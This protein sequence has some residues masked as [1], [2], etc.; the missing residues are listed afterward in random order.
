MM[1]WPFQVGF[2]EPVHASLDHSGVARASGPWCGLNVEHIEKQVS[3]SNIERIQVLLVKH[4]ESG[5]CPIKFS[6]NGGFPLRIERFSY[7]NIEK[8]S[9]SDCNKEQALNPKNILPFSKN[10]FP[11]IIP[12]PI[13][14]PS[15]L[16]PGS[17]GRCFGAP[18]C[19]V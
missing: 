12:H 10:R 14:K 7:S 4:R 13:P 18:G 2:M 6:T 11:K 5:V 9:F 16:T 8:H 1:T 17:G 15:T 3:D 19:S